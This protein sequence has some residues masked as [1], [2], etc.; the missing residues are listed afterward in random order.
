MKQLL[1]SIPLSLFL[2]SSIKSFASE[3]AVRSSNNLFTYIQDGGPLMIAIVG[4]AV[5]A[6]TIIIER[7]IYFTRKKAWT[8]KTL[9]PILE[10]A[11]TN[12]NAVFKEELENDLRDEF[13]LHANDLEKGLGLLSGCGNLAPVLGFLGTVIGMISAFA[14]IA[15]ATTVNAKVVAVGIQIA[16][17]TTASGLI[18]AAPILF[19]YYL[20]THII[21]NRY[22]E[23]EKIITRLSASLPRISEKVSCE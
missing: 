15:A 7:A 10:N 22:I 1:K 6:L 4:L 13:Q 19:S 20:F 3:D 23:S 2:L 5:I 8:V 14:A 12:S 9:I 17:I 18:V 11:K 21:H 16:L